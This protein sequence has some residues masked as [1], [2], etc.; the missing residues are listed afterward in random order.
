M[1]GQPP[2]CHAG[3]VNDVSWGALALTLTLLGAL[4]TWWAWRNRGAVAG[5]R[6]I[7][8]TLLPVAAWLTGLMPLLGQLTSAVT[9]WATRLVFSPVVWMGVSVAGLAVVLFVV[10]GF[11]DRRRSSTLPAGGDGTTRTSKPTP[12]ARGRKS[13]GQ[14]AADDDFDEIEALLRQRGIQ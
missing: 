14:P 13:V 12:A 11:V 4:W 10:T 3:E 6:G 9:G 5:V 1:V 8:W 7:A 2:V